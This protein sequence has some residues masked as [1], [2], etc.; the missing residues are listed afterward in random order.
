VGINGFPARR[1]YE[2]AQNAKV[3]IGTEKERISK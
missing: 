1:K 3:L 2:F